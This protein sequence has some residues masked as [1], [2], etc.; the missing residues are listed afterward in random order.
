MKLSRLFLT[1]LFAFWLPLLAITVSAREFYVSVTGADDQPGTSSQPL[2]TIQR[3][4]T[5]A[6]PG[7][8]ITVRAGVYRERIN[9]S[10]GGT[11][12]ACR[13]VFQAAPGE[14][15]EITGAERATN[16][17]RIQPDVWQTILPNA[18]FGGFNPYSDLIHGD[19]FNDQG[20]HHHTGAVYFNG[21]WLAEAA[22]RADLLQ[23]PATN[24]LWFGVVDATNTTIWAQFPGVDP[25]HQCVEI[26]ARQTVFYPERTGI[27]YLTVRGFILRAAATPWS[28][29]TAEQIGLIGTHWSR[30]W[31]IESNQISHSLCAG[32]TLGKYGDEWDNRAESAA[33][34]T[35][36]IRRALTNGWNA[37]TIGHH[38]IR[39]NDISFCEQAGIAGS[40]GGAFS[41]ITGNVI[42]EIHVRR[43][44]SGAEMAGIKLHGGID[45]QITQNHIYHCCTGI[46]LDW[47]GQGARLSQN[48]FHDNAWQDLF[49]EV[50]HGPLLVDNN[51]LLSRKSLKS[52]SDGVAYVHNLFGGTVE[53]KLYD[54]RI[55]PFLQPHAT[56]LAGFH[57]NPRGGDRY[58][59]NLFAGPAD[60][61][62]YGLARL[63]VA[64]SGNLFLGG[65]KPCQCEPG[66]LVRPEFFSS[67]KL[68]QKKHGWYLA[69]NFDPSWLKAQTRLLVTTS[70]LGSAVIPAAAYEQPNG[71]PLLLNVDYWGNLRTAVS[72]WPG[73]FASPGPMSATAALQVWPR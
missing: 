40:L 6:Q 22:A 14:R 56:A 46:W 36:T 68:L 24:H 28:P 30:G 60:L 37:A 62:P 72:L 2:R 42:H 31:I 32:V 13:I 34:Y 45:V 10:R 53:S 59:N 65:A 21:N 39:D 9:P 23:M 8:N 54:N 41:T 7:D 12:D 69:L 70:L 4:A 44:F 57:D 3:A 29:P 47:M 63:P 67:L 11:S 15:V 61:S 5:L 1:K 18:F 51:V 16:W 17:G 20:R 73:P 66:A 35:A 38:L 26:N 71:D 58:Y 55:T 43:L 52:W 49:L 33:G 25:N 48:L 27:N 19:W 64:M 50:N